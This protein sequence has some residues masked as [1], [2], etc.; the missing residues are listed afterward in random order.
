MTTRRDV[1]SLLAA[2][3][4]TG[5][6][7][8]QD[9]VR[10]PL[11]AEV[12]AGKLPP[13]DQRLPEIPRV[14][15]L[16]AMGRIPGRHGG[17]VRML[18][19]GQR[20]IRY[21]TIFGYARLAGYNEKLDLEPDILQDF[22]VE[23]E[24][25]FTFRLRPGHKWSD[26]HPL[27]AEDFRYAWED[28]MLNEKLSP[29][30]VSPTL[31]VNDKPPTF[32]VMDQYTVRY[33]WDGPNPDFMPWLAAAQ[34][35]AMVMPAHYLKQFHAKY[36]SEEKLD[37][38]IKENKVKNWA[39]LHINMSR[40][41]RPEN[42][43]LPM[44]DP[45]INSTKPPAE[46]FILQRNPYFHRVDRDGRQLPYFDRFVFNVSS[47]SLIPA[48]TGAG[49]T[50][51]QA[52]NIQFE[53]YTFLKESEKRHAIKVY[54]WERTQ[55]SRVA[56]LPN[57]NYEDAVWRGVLQDARFRQALSLAIDRR[58]INM[59]TF[60]G[61]GHPSADTMLPQSPL[62][63]PEYRDAWIAHDPAKANALLDEMGLDKRDDDGWRVLPDGRTAQVIVESAGDST[64]DTD[65]LELIADYWREISIPLYIR[66]S[67][68]EVLRSRALAGQ[69][70]MS[71]S[72]GIDNGIANADMNPGALAPT[73]DEELQWPIWGMNFVTR[74]EKGTAPDLAPVQELM[75]LLRDW[76]TAPDH[77]QRS[78]IW[79]R[80]LKLYTDQV[81]SIG[82]VNGTLQPIVANAKIK[83][84][85]STAFYGF[86]PTCY[87]GVYRA[88][89]FFYEDGAA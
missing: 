7:R 29:G 57:L 77:E 33:S 37:A 81:F 53:D 61:L 50:D 22:T 1:L 12:Q 5:P 87:F 34:P 9:I 27:T 23:E 78:L 82:L 88:D 69:V 13:L 60:F 2:A 72:S 51:L 25:V 8:A 19:S 42:P 3:A 89:T 55:G 58:E 11:L 52:T 70:M 47:S 43:D 56:L 24:R 59:A 74:G 28:V 26:G 71:I 63:R 6:A 31:I 54:L 10:D 17:T 48:K 16:I 49:E 35:L 76:R 84:L 75:G 38:L 21:I 68:I 30:G 66:T 18:I 14:T 64:L 4:L 46:Q 15:D 36:Q 44:L 86:D 79:H 83:N 73:G 40:Q 45:W 65:V 41:Y 32:E 62:F 85:P 80:M 39:R 67:Q 20:D